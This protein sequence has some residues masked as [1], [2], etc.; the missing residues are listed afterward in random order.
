MFSSKAVIVSIQIKYFDDSA[1]SALRK[2][3][4][5]A[6]EFDPTH[7]NFFLSQTLYNS[8]PSIPEDLWFTRILQRFNEHLV[9]SVEL[10]GAIAR[11]LF[12]IL[13]KC[14]TENVQLLR[15]WM[16]RITEPSEQKSVFSASYNL[17]LSFGLR[18]L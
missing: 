13:D 2:L 4:D 14:E 6:Q 11:P 12:Y 15:P 5:I 16:R 9:D 18:I 1:V 10:Y 17:I 7:K 3:D 8:L